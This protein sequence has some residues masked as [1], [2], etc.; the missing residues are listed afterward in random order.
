[1]AMQN[2]VGVDLILILRAERITSDAN[3]LMKP[4]DIFGLAVRI[5][6][7]IFLY[8]FV[9]A[10]PAIF[11]ILFHG[12]A[13]PGFYLCYLLGLG[14]AAWGIWWLIGGAPCLCEHAYPTSQDDDKP[15]SETTPD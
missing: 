8:Q 2:E 6:G 5:L 14:L 9:L 4:K 7:L 12:G 3:D 11:S 1:M 10:L 13:N 15:D